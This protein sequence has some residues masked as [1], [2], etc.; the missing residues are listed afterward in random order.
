MWHNKKHK[1][2]EFEGMG[3]IIVGDGE[4]PVNPSRTGWVTPCGTLILNQEDAIK[5]ATKLNEVIQDNR[6]LRMKKGNK[7]Q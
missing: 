7:F 3:N 4:L 2:K 1:Y 6:H 5:Y